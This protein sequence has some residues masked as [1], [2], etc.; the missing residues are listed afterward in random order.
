MTDFKIR[1]GL[2]TQLFS[3]PGVVNP[4]V[5]IEEGC[6]YLCTDTVELFLGVV[7]T[8]TNKLTLKQ[9]NGGISG[10]QNSGNIDLSAVEARIEQLENSLDSLDNFELYQRIDNESDLPTDFSAEDFN[11]NVTYYIPLAGNKINTFVFDKISQCYLCTN[12]VDELVVRA[13]VAD[14]IENV[15]EDTFEAKIPQMIK[16]TLEVT[17]LHGGDATP[18]DGIN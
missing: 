4:R 13:M 15:L 3:A 7:D 12:S 9:I 8:G 18:E 17:I 6:W 1:R 5:A 11:P 2:S 16:Q 10:G 14:A